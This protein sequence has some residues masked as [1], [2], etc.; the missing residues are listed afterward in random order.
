MPGGTDRAAPA[1]ALRQPRQRQRRAH[2]EADE[3]FEPIAATRRHRHVGVQAEALEPG[4]ARPRGGGVGRRAEAAH[5]LPGARTERD[6]PLERGRQRA[7]EQRR[8]RRE[9]VA[10]GV[11][12]RQPAAARQKP[13]DAPV[14]PREERRDVGIARRRQAVEDRPRGGQRARVDAVEDQRV[15]MHIGVERSAKP[16][17]RG[18]APAA[19]LDQAP[20][21]RAPPLP[22]EHSAQ[23]HP[24]HRTGEAGPEADPSPGA[25]ASRSSG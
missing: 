2:E 23:E 3:V 1:R 14:Q 18:D 5:G 12:F 7:G 19:S 13:A 15:E 11:V 10:P 21:G 24:Q 22:A 6:P 20:P 4:A 9:Q 17:K 8:L 16:L 25:G